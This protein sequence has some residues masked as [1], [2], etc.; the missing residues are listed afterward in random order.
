MGPVYYQNRT[1]PCFWAVDKMRNG[2]WK[3]AVQRWVKCIMRKFALCGRSY[4][5]GGVC[6]F[7]AGTANAGTAG[8]RP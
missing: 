5:H 2:N 7:Y 8:H 6:L 1:S 3:G 4:V